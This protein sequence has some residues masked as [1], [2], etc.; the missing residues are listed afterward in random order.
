VRGTGFVGV[1]GYSATGVGV[2]ADSDAPFDP[3]K[4]LVPALRASSA[5]S[6]AI[7]GITDAAAGEI[8]PAVRGYSNHT[9][10]VLGDGGEN[11][12]YGLSVGGVAVRAWSGLGTGVWA[13]CHP[14]E[15]GLAV[16]TEGHV[17]FRHISGVATIPAG[18]TSITI[19]PRVG[20]RATSFVLL[21]PRTNLGPRALWYVTD[22]I[23]SRL[24][25]K[26]SSPRTSPTRIGWLLL[27]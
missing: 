23:R 20:V 3:R 16:K 17:E 9:T 12:V 18:K 19:T 5:H 27:N 4:E 13:S 22:R 25:I 21:T 24:T 6:T 14:L 26:I 8:I 2:T 15:E 10:G 7:V 1:A 11:G